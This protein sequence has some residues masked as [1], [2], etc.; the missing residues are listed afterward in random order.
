MI[1]IDDEKKK[2]FGDFQPAATRWR[3]SSMMT[4]SLIHWQQSVGEHRGRCRCPRRSWNRGIV[5]AVTYKFHA[6]FCFGQDAICRPA[7]LRRG[8]GWLHPGHGLAVASVARHHDSSRMPEAFSEP[9]WPL[10]CHRISSVNVI[11]LASSPSY[12]DIDGGRSTLSDLNFGSAT[13]CSSSSFL[14]G[15]R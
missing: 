11:T 15:R 7:G 1:L 12:S 5:D 9:R 2:S 8:H 14:S 13:F 10:P 3:S 4:M 6:M